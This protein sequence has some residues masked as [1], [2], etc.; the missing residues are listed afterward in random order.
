MNLST[1]QLVKVW[2]TNNVNKNL[3]LYY[4]YA[5]HKAVF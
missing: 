4:Y 3:K 5:I 2:N 1:L